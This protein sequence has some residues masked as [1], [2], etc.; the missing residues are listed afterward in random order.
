MNVNDHMDI[1]NIITIAS[2]KGG[3]AK[4]TTTLNLGAALAERGLRVLLID[5]D[6]ERHLSNSLGIGITKYN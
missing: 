3:T 2:A 5:N 1:C 4:T 6:P